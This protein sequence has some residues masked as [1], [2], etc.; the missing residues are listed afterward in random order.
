MNGRLYRAKIIFALN[1]DLRDEIKYINDKALRHEKNYQIWHHRQLVIDRLNDPSGETEFIARMF[2]KDAK[3]YHVWSYRQWLVKRF[4]FWD[5]ELR[6][7]AELEYLDWLLKKDVRNNSAWNH[8]FFLV[9][10]GDRPETPSLE[11]V[12]TELRCGF[13]VEDEEEE[14]T[15]RI[16]G[17]QKKQSI[18][19]PKT[20][21]RGTTYVG[22]LPHPGRPF[23]Q[24]EANIRY[25]QPGCCPA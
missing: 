18:L 3:N 15:N 7:A 22:N 25:A 1:I 10:G 23:A 2:E 16:A 9:F 21:V 14:G 11:V 17:L 20:P 5:D 19:R 4:R 12:K 13:W 6:Y 8:R 24:C